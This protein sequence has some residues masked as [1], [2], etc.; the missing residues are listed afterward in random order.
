MKQSEIML[1]HP[2]SDEHNYNHYE[3]AITPECFFEAL[4]G[5]GTHEFHNTSAIS[6]N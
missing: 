4:N 5:I 2:C 6:T 3:T 1:N